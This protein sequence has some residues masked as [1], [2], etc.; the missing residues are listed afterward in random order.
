[1]EIMAIVLLFSSRFPQLETKGSTV[2]AEPVFV[3]VVEP[4]NR[5]RQAGN[6]FLGP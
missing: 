3:N 6:L 5:F 4:N 2:T 1:M